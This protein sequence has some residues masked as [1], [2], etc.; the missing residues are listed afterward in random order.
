MKEKKKRTKIKTSKWIKENKMK[1]KK[2]MM[3]KKKIKVN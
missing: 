1:E 2:K 3:K